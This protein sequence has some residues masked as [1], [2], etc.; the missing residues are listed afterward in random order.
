MLDLDH[1]HRRPA[2]D[3][4]AGTSALEPHHVIVYFAKQYRGPETTNV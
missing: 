4:T 2:D 3:M 1:S